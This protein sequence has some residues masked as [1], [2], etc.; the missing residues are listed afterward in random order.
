[1]EQGYACIYVS[2]MLCYCVSFT[3]AL[4]KGKPARYKLDE[5]ANFESIDPFLEFFLF[6]PRD[7]IVVNRSALF[8]STVSRRY[9]VFTV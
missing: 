3:C 8:T 7:V 9:P 6:Q 5:N 2:I 4:E 1:M